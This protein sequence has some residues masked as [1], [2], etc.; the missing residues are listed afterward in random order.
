MHMPEVV[1]ETDRQLAARTRLA[2]PDPLLVSL[3][4]RSGLVKTKRGAE[5]I[6]LIVAALCFIGMFVVL[7]TRDNN[8]A[9]YGNY[10]T[11][12]QDHPEFAE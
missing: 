2:K 9:S 10:E 8:A 5:F 4:K 12:I 1:F 11:F 3:L 6:L 7:G